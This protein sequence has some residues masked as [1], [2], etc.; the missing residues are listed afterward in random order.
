MMRTALGFSATDNGSCSTFMEGGEKANHRYLFRIFSSAM[1]C[2]GSVLHPYR[3]NITEFFYSDYRPSHRSVMYW[4]IAID[5]DCS[6]RTERVTYTHA[7]VSCERN[8]ISDAFNGQS[9][10][11]YPL[12]STEDICIAHASIW[13]RIYIIFLLEVLFCSDW[14]F[15]LLPLSFTRQDSIFQIHDH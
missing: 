11:Y 8:S 6:L 15:S 9:G 1:G 4:H 10:D 13:E 14:R 5:R 3:R 12:F 7:C 2:R